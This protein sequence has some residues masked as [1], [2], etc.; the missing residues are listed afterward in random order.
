MKLRIFLMVGVIVALVGAC[1]PITPENSGAGIVATDVWARAAAT[2]NSAAYMTLKN[3]DA[4]ADR[5]VDLV[6][7]AKDRPD[8]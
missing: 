5:L 4:A 6:A 8:R 1:T 7:A 2:G 3:G